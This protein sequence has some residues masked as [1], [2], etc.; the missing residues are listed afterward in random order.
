[1]SHS[2]T[3]YLSQP[4]IW[5]NTGGK[6]RLP[7]GLGHLGKHSSRKRIRR[8]EVR[9]HVRFMGMRFGPN[10][11]LWSIVCNSG[12]GTAN[13]KFKS[14]PTANLDSNLLL[15]YIDFSNGKELI[16]SVIN[17]LRGDNIFHVLADE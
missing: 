3:T 2:F 12:H 6:S 8:V 17:S 13:P 5:E 1:M 16:W 14:N 11:G 15:Q 10:S 7:S 9:S 4:S